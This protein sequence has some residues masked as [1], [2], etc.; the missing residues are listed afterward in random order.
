LGYFRAPR[1]GFFSL[2]CR[3]L[4][5]LR[6]G[7]LITKVPLPWYSAEYSFS[8]TMKVH[9]RM[10]RLLACL[11]LI[12]LLL[13]AAE[14][15]LFSEVGTIEEGLSEITGLRFTRH[16]PYALINKMQLR[17]YLEDRIKESIKPADMR[18]E[19]LTLKLLGLIP[20]DFDLRQNTVDLLTE[21]AAAFYD[22][23]KRK[24]FVLEGSDAGS[25]ER[26]VLVHE[27]AHAL[28]DQHFPLRKYINEGLQSDDGSTARL[29]VME[30]QATW[31]MA[32]YLSKLGGGPAEVPDSV[33]QLMTS[34]VDNSPAQ[35]PVFSQAP[36]YIR[37]SLV[38]PY[39]EGMLFQNAVYKKLGRA[40]F[41]EVFRHPPT[42]TQQILHPDRYL[43]HSAPATPDPPAVPAH[44]DVRELAEGSL[45]EFDFRVL[46]SQYTSKE[47]GEQAATHLAGG[48]YA[49]FEYKHGKLPLLA[50][51]ST[52]DSDDS[53]GKYIEL[54]GRVLQGKWKKLEI[55]SQTAAEI[56]GHGDTG[57]FRAWKDGARV[58]H[59]EGLHSPIPG[60]QSP[61]H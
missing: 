30:G 54:Y 51:A 29:A 33:L 14:W 18:A 7:L 37:E 2:D 21:Q 60:P 22:Y 34:T 50:F 40:A 26:M 28:A 47:E 45:G 38:F 8:F 25:E 17:R 52:W 16:V 13:G 59:L 55:A 42:S 3:S 4:R 57:Y 35:Y 46:L 5:P 10:K 61:V 20:P 11:L 19:E 44:R 27:L 31:L 6:L 48:S 9:C 24:L 15:P 23:N 49:V 36:L 41:S 53:A 56:T 32:A 39:N 43:S 58:Y 1:C 12:A